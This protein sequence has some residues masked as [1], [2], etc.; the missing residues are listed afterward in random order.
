MIFNFLLPTFASMQACLAHAWQSLIPRQGFVF[1]YQ[2]LNFSGISWYFR[3]LFLTKDCIFVTITKTELQKRPEEPMIRPATSFNNVYM[4]DLDWRMNR[5]ICRCI[6]NALPSNTM[7]V[8]TTWTWSWFDTK[9]LQQFDNNCI[10]VSLCFQDYLPRPAFRAF[11]ALGT[12]IEMLA[13][14]GMIMGDS[15]QMWRSTAVV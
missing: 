11:G 5:N 9:V 7:Y 15:W 14:I 10:K 12:W 1:Q 2:F 3:R 8:E 4:L 6:S 13:G